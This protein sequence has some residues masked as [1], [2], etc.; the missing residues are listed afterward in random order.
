MKHI[1]R[2]HLTPIALD[3][4]VSSMAALKTMVTD[5]WPG[6]IVI[7]PALMGDPREVMGLVEHLLSRTVVSSVFE[8]GIGMSAVLQLARAM[9]PPEPDTALGFGT[10]AWFPED[11]PLAGGFHLREGRLL[12]PLISLPWEKLIWDHLPK[13]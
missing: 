12:E 5:G 3:E 4:S 2:E 6:W 8:T 1:A 11:D 10:L 13:A 7:K 9:L